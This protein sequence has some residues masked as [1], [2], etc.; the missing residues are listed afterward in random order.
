MSAWTFILLSPFKLLLLRLKTIKGIQIWMTQNKVKL[1]NNKTERL[2]ITPSQCN[3][4]MALVKMS[5]M[6]VISQQAKGH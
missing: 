5:L 6:K 2:F 1:N 3:Q 4:N